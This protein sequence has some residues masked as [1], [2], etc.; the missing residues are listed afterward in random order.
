MT[1]LENVEDVYP[2]SPIQQGML[3]HTIADPDSGVFVN[4][5]S[6]RLE[7]ELDPDIFKA[8]WADLV[9]RHSILRS[10][11]VW[12]GVD[13]P[14]QVVRQQAHLEWLEEDWTAVPEDEQS[15]RLRELLGADRRR[16]FNLATAPL[17]RMML[18][19]TGGSAWRWVWS[20]HH[21]I[22]DGWS[23]QVLLDELISL[24]AGRHT[25]EDPALAPPFRYR[26]FIA[27]LAQQTDAEQF[28][29]DRLGGF[30]EPHHLEVP[31]IPPDAGAS[32]HRSH[33]VELDAATTQALESMA[34]ENHVTLNSAVV[35]AW[36]LLLSRWTREQ[37][38]VFGVTT[39]GRDVGTPGL[40]RGVGL[41]INTLP[42]RVEVPPERPLADW[43]RQLQDQQ[44]DARRHEQSSLAAVQR[45]SDAPAGAALFE[46]IFVFENYPP[47]ADRARPVDFEL[48]EMDYIE[49]SNY[50]LAV[51]VV[52][53]ERL[54]VSFVYDTARFAAEAVE[55]LGD[56]LRTLLAG[57]AA[58]PGRRL[59]EFS[60]LSGG[61]HERLHTLIPGPDPASD[62]RC[63]HE[64]IEAIAAERP[65]AAAVVF[66][67][68]SLSYRDLD[69]AGNRLAARLQAAGVGPNQ[70][71]GLYLP[72]SIEMIVGM[73]G[74]LKAGGAYVPLDPEYP[75]LHVRRLLEN[76]AIEMVVTTRGL[77]QHVPDTADSLLVDG[78]DDR[79]PVKPPST[80]QNTDL[81]Y[82]IHTSGSTGRP[83][84]VAV[85]HRNLVHSTLARDAHYGRPVGRFLLLSSFAFDSSVVGIFWTLCSGGTLV[86]PAP[87]L[88]QDIDR[89]VALAADEGA[90]H[91]L[92]LPALYQLLVEHA[93]D[94]EL[95]SLEVAIVAGEACPSAVLESHIRRVPHAE[96]HNE[97]GPTEATVWCSAHRATAADVGR[98]LPIG[99]PIA[100]TRLYILDSHGRLVP[101]GFAGELCVAGEGVATGYL[102]RPDLTAE[103]FVAA[104]IDGTPERLY[105]TGDLAA[106]RPDGSLEFLGRA[107][108]QLKIRG[109]RIETNAV[110]AAIRSQPSVREAAVTGHRLDGRP[111]AQLVAYVSWEDQSADVGALRAALHTQLPEFMVP[112]VI[113]P[114]A[115]MPRLPNGKLDYA[116]LPDPRS[117]VPA[118]AAVA[119]RTDVEA[120]LA[121]IWQELL[122]IDDLSVTDD[123]FALGGDSIISIQMISR[124]RQH[125]LHIEPGQITRSPTVEGLAAAAGLSSP[126]TSHG[127]PVSG[128]V[129][130]GPMQHWFFD[131]QMAVPDHWNQSTLYEVPADVD[132]SALQAA[133]QA[134]VDHHDMLRA[135][136]EHHDDGW[137]QTIDPGRELILE[138]VEADESGAFA[139]IRTVQAGLDL[140]NGPVARALLLR[141]VDTGRVFLLLAVHHLVVDAVSWAVLSEDISVAYRQARE[142]AAISL[143]ERTTSFRDWVRLLGE[144]DRSD[145][146]SFW[147]SADPPADL[148]RDRT[149]T[150]SGTE[151]SARLLQTLLDPAAT[152]HLMTAANEAYNSRAEDLLIAA[153]G[154]AL[155]EWSGSRNIRVAVEGHG[156]PADVAGVDLSRTVGWFTAY[157]PL[158]MNLPRGEG[159]IIKYVKERLRA[160]PAGGIGYGALR[161]LDRA[162]GFS[163]HT[164]PEVLFNYLSRARD[165]RA[166]AFLT[167]V[168]GADDSSRDD[169]NPRSHLVEVVAS[170]QS[171]RLT[172]NWYFSEAVHDV[173]TIKHVANRY[174]DILTNLVE[175]CLSGAAGGFTPSDFPEAGLGQAELDR[176]L[177]GI[178]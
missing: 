152:H 132:H 166:D 178:A 19:R 136:F 122:G 123:F 170:V 45:W 95:D 158:S 141:R 138:T 88:E 26:D 11:F 144:Q 143:P 101:P 149:G 147:L 32:G 75:A 73:V 169:R 8:A 37:D 70:P 68:K 96:L 91:L 34:R 104:D 99:R 9:A 114:V 71:I 82:V 10:A 5:I 165:T 33:T 126:A 151:A 102:G 142:S 41:F 81:A 76:D 22:V 2:L 172:V 13:E 94:G 49:Q 47:P 28:W 128:T 3:F 110:E 15:R 105:R 59:A 29:R 129:P 43:L 62:D 52:P 16:G 130:L 116:R 124:A 74:I 120:T 6:A 157:Y 173:S 20:T 140:Q 78:D 64:I 25:G 131:S 159:E 46:S 31:G 107:D 84:G 27:G 18:I 69:E 7:G 87:K 14:L 150:G 164:D 61:D 112:D 108:R 168:A 90:T 125:G 97:Y 177:D 42:F 72:R 162:D 134:C 58:S 65:E 66:E 57:F 115:D 153:L 23:A 119:P 121:S 51:L 85:T 38:V 30:V 79:A 161:Y 98:P 17:T 137:Q 92:C 1:A 160:V 156:R 35:A 133:L 106:Y 103:R 50:P 39:A 77:Q 89:L 146:R 167:P 80:V 83:K 36:S 145:Q 175:H 54:M 127:G 4:Q 44:L 24:Y 163:G 174:M 93:G 12:D 55:G 86:L 21:M 171:D 117:L 135:R 109:H 118:H 111:T 154:E 155:A 53:G 67:G 63:V 60:L 148:P 100:G 113:V 40:E 48:L 56:Q 139:A 176:F